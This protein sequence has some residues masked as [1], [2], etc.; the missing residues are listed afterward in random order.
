MKKVLRALYCRWPRIMAVLLLG[1]GVY[2]LATV[3]GT[4]P[5]Y[6]YDFDHSFSESVKKEII[7]FLATQEVTCKNHPG[8]L[9]NVQKA[10]PLI[11]GFQT[12]WRP[13]G[14]VHTSLES[15]N[16]LLIMN[17]DM[18]LTEHQQLLPRAWWDEKQLSRLH[19][20]SCE[21]SLYDAQQLSCLTKLPPATFAFYRLVVQDQFAYVLQDKQQSRFSIKFHSASVPTS[22]VL[23]QCADIKTELEAQGAFAGKKGRLWV[24]DVRFAKQIIMQSS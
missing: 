21:A 15:H 16:P 22:T 12:S 3:T 5:V 13:K 23:A 7:S 4:K 1:G 18:V 6:C 17:N 14:L 11:A 10:Y 9:V 19:E 2:R 20:F 24:A 8:R